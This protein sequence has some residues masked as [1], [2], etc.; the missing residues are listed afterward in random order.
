MAIE[1]PTDLGELVEY[2]DGSVVSHALVKSEAG[3]VTAFAFDQG[4]GLSEHSAPYD[5][6]LQVVEGSATVNIGGEPHSVSAGQ[7]LRL[8]AEV[9][10]ALKADQRFKMLLV[11]IRSPT[12]TTSRSYQRY[13]A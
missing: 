1:T 3:T 9:P 4:E 11:M 10:H 8:P 6:L 2:Q 5:A 12:T 7:I 13:G